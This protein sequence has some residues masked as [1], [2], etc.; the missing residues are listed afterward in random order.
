MRNYSGLLVA[1]GLVGFLYCS[2]ELSKLEPVPPG[3]SMGRAFE[4]PAGKMEMGR[5]ASAALAFF[6]ILMIMVRR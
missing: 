5:Y 3:L 2:A 4:Y 1:V 6:G